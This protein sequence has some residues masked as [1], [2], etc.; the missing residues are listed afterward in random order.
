MASTGRDWCNVLVELLVLSVDA[1]T[2][3]DTSGCF[4]GKMSGTS[5][6]YRFTENLLLDAIP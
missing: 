1:S 3:S 6:L 2:L 5:K 4:L